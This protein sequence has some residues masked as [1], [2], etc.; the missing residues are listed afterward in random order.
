MFRIHS[1]KFF[2]RIILLCFI[3]A[4]SGCTG[5]VFRTGLNGTIPSTNVI[6]KKVW[7]SKLELSDYVIQSPPLFR[8]IFEN[9]TEINRQYSQLKPHVEE[10]LTFSILKSLRDGHY[11]KEVNA[12]PGNVEAEDLILKFQFDRY[13]EKSTLHPLA[14]P[15][16]IAFPLFPLYGFLGG[17]LVINGSELSGTLTVEDI[18]GSPL[19]QVKSHIKESN[20][21]FFWSK[22]NYLLEA[23]TFIIN[24]LLT[25]ALIE[26]E[27]IPVKSNES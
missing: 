25:K 7:L 19:A 17:P 2:W 13:L 15:F 5:L 12:L 24:D 4:S 21:V 6:N 8:R 26:L 20:T 3:V 23:R 18:D 10:F 16:L 22:R 11:F 14:T 1:N 27:Q 9:Q